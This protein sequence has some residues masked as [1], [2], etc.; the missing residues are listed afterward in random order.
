MQSVGQLWES[1][2]NYSFAPFALRCFYFSAAY[3]VRGLTAD[4][5]RRFTFS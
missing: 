2:E 4:N 5:V 3:A 1:G